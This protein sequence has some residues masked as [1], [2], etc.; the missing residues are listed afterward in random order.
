M[1]RISAVVAAVIPLLIASQAQAQ[2]GYAAKEI[3]RIQSLNDSSTFSSNYIRE[4]VYRNAGPRLGLSAT[5][6]RNLFGNALNRPNKPFSSVSKGP[7]VT[8]Y[9]ALDQP[10]TNSA[11]QYYTQIRPRQE[12]QRL[13]QQMERQAQLM[14][15][16][17]SEV[18]ARPPYNP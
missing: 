17:L 15:R 9:L 8:P 18:T 10:F 12:Q 16:Q 1:K 5:V 3:N 6:S 14:Q 13:N 2:S 4:S 7:S 11:T